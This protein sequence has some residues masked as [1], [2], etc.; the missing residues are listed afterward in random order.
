MPKTSLDLMQGTV[1]VLILKTLSWG[2]LHGYDISRS[3][4]QRSDGALG[5]EDAALYQALHRLERKGWIEAEWGLSENNRRAK[6][7]PADRR[8]AAGAPGGAVDLAD[9]CG[10]RLQGAGDRLSHAPRRSF[11]FPRRTAAQ[12]AADVEEELAFHLDRMAEELTRRGVAAGGGPGGGPAPVRGSRSDTRPYCRALDASKE[13]QMKWMERFA[14]ARP[15]SPLRRAAARAKSPAFTLVAVLTLALGIG[16]T[17]AIFSVVYGVLLRPLPFQAPERLVRPYFVGP[18]AR[19]T[20]AFSPPNFLDFRAA[21][22]TLA[23]LTSVEGGTLNLSGDGAEPERLQAALVGANFF[24]V[25]GIRPLRGP[26]LRAGR[27]PGRA[28][29][30]WR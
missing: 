19:R 1:A 5:L 10:R 9:L 13:R 17:T 27:G 20:A 30:A 22:R 2:A 4:R 14:R 23:D 7:L 29:P 25:L 28:P 26:H 11:R 18:E 16:A 3:I 15:G 12:V 21:S 8:R 6:L 24:K